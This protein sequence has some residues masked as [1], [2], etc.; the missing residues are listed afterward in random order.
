IAGFDKDE[1][2]GINV[3]GLPPSIAHKLVIS[4]AER[5]DSLGKKYNRIAAQAFQITGADLYVLATDDCAIV[6]HGWDK[7]LADIVSGIPDRIAT[8]AF[9][10]MGPVYESA[11]PAMLAMTKQMKDLNGEF[12]TPYFP[13]WWHDTGMYEVAV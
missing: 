11:N 2:D 1:A 10:S 8:L 4:I 12:C 13:T 5:E 9:G 7:G 3:E 6:T